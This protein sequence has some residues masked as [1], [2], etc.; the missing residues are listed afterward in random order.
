M[1]AV[2]ELL[3]I[4][5]HCK[6]NSQIDDIRLGTH[7]L[8]VSVVFEGSHRGFRTES[9]PQVVV[10]KVATPNLN[11]GAAV[12]RPVRWSDLQNL[13]RLVVHKGHTVK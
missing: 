5:T 9:T 8:Q 1:A 6:G 3:V 10:F 2:T 13:R 11:P 7:A 4:H 12:L